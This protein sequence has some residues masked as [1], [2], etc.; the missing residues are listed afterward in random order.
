MPGKKNLLDFVLKKTKKKKTSS[1]KIYPAPL[2]ASKKLSVPTPVPVPR[3]AWDNDEQPT[4]KDAATPP[5]KTSHPSR[6]GDEWSSKYRDPKFFLGNANVVGNV[7]SFLNRRESMPMSKPY[8]LLLTGELGCGKTMVV[9]KAACETQFSIYRVNTDELNKKQGQQTFFNALT[10]KF[11]KKTMVLLDNVFDLETA[12]FSFLTSTLQRMNGK[13]PSA[14]KDASPPLPTNPLV[15]TGTSRYTNKK[16]VVKRLCKEIQMPLPSDAFVIRVLQR[17]A[18]NENLRVNLRE[19]LSTAS[20][21]KNLNSLIVKLQMHQ[22]ASNRAAKSTTAS[23]FT[24]DTRVDSQFDVVHKIRW[25]K[26]PLAIK[27]FEKCFGKFGVAGLADMVT[28]NLEDNR[29]TMETCFQF[30]ESKSECDVLGIES[31]SSGALMAEAFA[32]L[33]SSSGKPQRVQVDRRHK[34]PKQAHSAFLRACEGHSLSASEMVDTLSLTH[35]QAFDPFPPQYADEKGW[36][37]KTTRKQN[38]M[39]RNLV[40]F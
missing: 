40:K 27:F 39:V 35:P 20:N 29:T 30:M 6:G 9:E 16:F 25:A 19:F 31:S 26:A 11:M 32:R 24:L 5:K 34:N 38:A 1:Q 33:A 10:T 2:Q 22:N 17:V 36:D 14:K 13:P 23:D 15:M 3:G 7:K 28:A 21:R 4:T 18:H 12:S 8:A 37:V